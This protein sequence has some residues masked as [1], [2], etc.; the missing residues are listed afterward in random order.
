MEQ[1][2]SSGKQELNI[3]N[4]A[5]GVYFVKIIAEGQEQVVRLIKQ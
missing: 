4:E 2:L 3:S 5:N 1:K